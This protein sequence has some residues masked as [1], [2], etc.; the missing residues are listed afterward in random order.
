M[1]LSLPPAASAKLYGNVKP[2]VSFES[3]PSPTTPS[4]TASTTPSSSPSSNKSSSTTPPRQKLR[5]SPPGIDPAV[6]SVLFL[7]K[8][9]ARHTRH[10][11]STPM[12]LEVS[13]KDHM[14]RKKG[15][16]E[17]IADALKDQDKRGA[18]EKARERLAGIKSSPVPAPKR[19]RVEDEGVEFYPRSIDFFGDEDKKKGAKRAN[20]KMRE[21]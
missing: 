16:M 11:K 12:K 8:D 18:A 5:R 6:A 19:Q 21:V 9:R 7:S 2:F 15:G 3:T 13:Y 20:E 14:G 1:F 4:S 10:H 17:A